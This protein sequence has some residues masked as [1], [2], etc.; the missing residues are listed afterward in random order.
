MALPIL[1]S[2]ATLE[3]QSTF[4]PL[5]GICPSPLFGL[6]NSLIRRRARS[7]SPTAAYVLA[8]LKP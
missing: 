4:S 6:K 2:R 5:E 7:Y 1:G 3:R 8:S